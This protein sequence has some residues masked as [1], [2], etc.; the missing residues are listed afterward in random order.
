[1]KIL[2]VASEVTPFAKTGG[3]ADVAAAL[4]KAL[5]QLG[6]DVRIIMPCYRSISQGDVPFRKARKSA[7]IE[8]G[9]EPLK[10]FL[11]QAALTDVPVYL[12]ENKHFFGRDYLYGSPEEDYPDNPRRFAFFCRAVLQL[13]KRMDFR[14][15][16]IHCHDWQTALIPIIL[17]AELGD[18]PFFARTA[19]VFTIHNLAYQ[20]L[21]PADALAEMG[22]SPALFTPDQLEYYGKVNLLKGAILAADVITTVSATYCREIMT[23]ES[24]CGLE[25]VLQS[26][27]DALFGIRNGLDTDEWNPAADRRIFRNYSA[28]SLAG[29]HADKLE[30]QRELGL[31]V[32]SSV[33]LIGMVGRMVEQKGIELLISLLPRLG[34]ERLQVV[35]LGTGDRDSMARLQEFK[36]RGSKNIS[37]TFGF[38]DELAPKIFAGSDLF[39]M[40]SR[41]EPCGL[42]QLIALRYGT[43]P[44]VRQTGGLADTIIDVTENPREGNGFS[45]S[46][47]TADACWDAIKRALAALGD[48]EGWRK[49]MRRGMSA[50]VSWRQ[51]AGKYEELYR[52]CLQKRK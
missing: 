1:M 34:S 32:S 21:F 40:P 38:H 45:F 13:L 3:L 17:R 19:V 16:V 2:L 11:R 10:G 44:V 20:G 7:E 25:G 26:R 35:I 42:S 52:T 22:L 37:I 23:P 39:L 18:D 27:A 48:R 30:L 9:G 49:I 33:P 6:H 43:V 24:G 12:V 15:D 29:K 47:Y 31:E 8:L 46:A 14:P 50:D 36:G 5:K 4:P 41:F 28:K 51:A